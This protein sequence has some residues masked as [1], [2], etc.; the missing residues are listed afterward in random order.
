M[1]PRPPP[2]ERR[3][4]IANDSQM[5][6]VSAMAMVLRLRIELRI[7]R[8][9]FQRNAIS[10]GPVEERGN[11]PGCALGLNAPTLG[12]SP[13]AMASLIAVLFCASAIDPS[14]NRYSVLDTQ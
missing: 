13:R 1:P 11:G 6:I 14:S 5:V 4:P 12:A 3:G 9:F 8:R 10:C 7:E 2:C